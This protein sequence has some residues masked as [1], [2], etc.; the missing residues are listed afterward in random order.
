MDYY[1]A[2]SNFKHGSLNMSTAANGTWYKAQ[3]SGGDFFFAA[4]GGTA[5]GANPDAFADTYRTNDDGTLGDLSSAAN[6]DE[7]GYADASGNDPV[8]LVNAST[9]YTSAS[10]PSHYLR[11]EEFSFTTST[12]VTNKLYFLLKR[13]STSG[14]LYVGFEPATAFEYRGTDE[15]LPSYAKAAVA[16]EKPGATDQITNLWTMEDG[17]T[18]PASTSVSA[19]VSNTAKFILVEFLIHQVNSSTLSVTCNAYLDTSSY[20]L[21]WAPDST[22]RFAT[23]NVNIANTAAATFMPTVSLD[24]NVHHKLHALMINV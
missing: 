13:T 12:S 24:N 17:G 9:S 8:C 1:E 3:K 16:L 22:K 6:R 2:K 15:T 14:P 10:S 4:A 19:T 5:N 11:F 7:V 18:S 23:V 21:L 20:S